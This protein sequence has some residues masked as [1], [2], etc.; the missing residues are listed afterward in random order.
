MFNEHTIS[1]LQ[2]RINK[3]EKSLLS[4]TFC[5]YVSTKNGYESSNEQTFEYKL[6]VHSQTYL[7]LTAKFVLGSETQLNLAL[8]L[9][10]V[11]ASN[12]SF[13]QKNG[14]FQVVLPFKR[15]E[16]VIKLHFSSQTEFLVESCTLET[17]GNLNYKEYDCILS[18]INESASSLVLF[19]VDGEATLRVY[20]DGEF[21]LAKSWSKVKSI[22]FCK[23]L[24]GYLVAYINDSSKGV[25]QAFDQDL[26]LLAESLF[27][28]ELISVCALSKDNGILFAVRGNS[29]YKYT[30]NSDLTVVKQKT[31]YNAKTVKS[32]PSVTDYLILTDYGGFSKLVAV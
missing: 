10:G 31:E 28:S 23:T 20:K 7:K 30:V 5:Y 18:N 11:P 29:V 22:A 25:L 17:F 8:Y 1:D 19:S 16:N 6:E 2:N 21:T 24:T 14:E 15:G 12:Y 32:N 27:D 13:T 26:N 9:N 3:L 4:P